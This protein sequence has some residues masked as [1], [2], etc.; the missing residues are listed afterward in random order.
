VT[1]KGWPASALDFYDGLEFDNSKDYWQAHKGVYESDVRAPMEALFAELAAE[2]GDGKIFRPNRD[3]RF[4][5]DKSPYKTNIGG[6][7]AKG[8]YVQFSGTGLAAGHGYYSME[9]DQLERFRAAI[10]DDYKG[11]QLLK[12][13]AK[14]EKAGIDIS[15]Y[16]S[17]KTAPRGFDKAHPRIEY[18]RRKNLIAWNEWPIEPWLETAAVTG[19]VAGFLRA[20]KPLGSWLDQ[21]VGPTEIVRERR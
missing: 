5:N 6:R 15:S 2:F 13:V 3:V 4:S 16:G 14:I 20:V 19:H 1:F 11:G 18:L 9:S 21:Y 10:D 8:G 12:V 7:L 17:L